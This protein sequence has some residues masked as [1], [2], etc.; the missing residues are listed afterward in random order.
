MTWLGKSRASGKKKTVR[1]SLKVA[2]SYAILLIILFAIASVAV[3]VTMEFLSEKVAPSDFRIAAYLVWSITL[4]FMLI[5]GAFGLW[6]IQ[7]AGAAEG[8]RRI[9]RFVDAMNYLEDGLLA[10]DRRG[11]VTGS[12]PAARAM[13]ESDLTDVSLR[14]VFPCLT[15]GD[16]TALRRTNRPVEVE[17]DLVSEQGVR[18]LRFRS[19]PSESLRLV[20]I[21]DVTAMKAQRQRSRQAARLQLIGHLARGV[22]HDFNE[23]LCAIDGHASLLPRLASGSQSFL[24]SIEAISRGAKGGIDLAN[25]LMR[26]SSASRTSPPTSRAAEHIQ[27][28]VDALRQ[29]LPEGWSVSA[30]LTDCPPIALTGVQVEQVVTN[31]CLLIPDHNGREGDILVETAP[32]EPDAADAVGGYA[33]CIRITCQHTSGNALRRQQPTETGVIESVIAGVLTEAGGK[34]D[35]DETTHERSYHIF[36]PRAALAD[37]RADD[38]D[39]PDDLV[40]ILGQWSVLVAVPRHRHERLDE[41]LRELGVQFTRV[42]NIVSA[43]GLV[44]QTQRLNA[45]LVDEHLLREEA[46]GLL[47]AMAKLR[48]SAGIVVISETPEELRHDV[49]RRIQFLGPAAR[50]RRILMAMVDSHNAAVQQSTT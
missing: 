48:P 32:L 47:N 50:P 10:I 2:W 40:A 12:N 14:D 34:L 11:R 4:G 6:T 17:R 24:D 15:A 35:R 44:E 30:N 7:F 27:L 3:H 28:A 41:Q 5:A 26:L 1:F 18:S 22:A 36:L 42:D 38:V 8:Q 25:Q 23:L 9:G 16:D 20:L 13:A 37:E 43:L 29:T 21:S 45:I 46:A 39:I 33:C 31:L 19:Q 49:P